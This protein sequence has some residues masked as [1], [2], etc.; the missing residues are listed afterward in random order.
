[1]RLTRRAVFGS[2]A[3]SRLLAQGVGRPGLIVRQVSPDNLES[4]FDALD[5]VVTPTEQFYVRS[6]F[7]VPALTAA[8]FRLRVEGRVAQPVQL[9]YDELL[10]MPSRTVTAT[11]ECAGNGRVFLSPAAAGVQW[12]LGAVSTAEW[13]GVPLAAVL[14]RAG[15]QPAA[16][17]IV[18]E[19]ADRGELRNDPRPPGPV[20]FARS[21]PLA[22]ARQP[23]VLLA[24]HMNGQ[25]LTA[26]HGFPLRAV[27][28]GWYGMASVKW[29]HRIVALDRPFTGYYQTV[30]YAYWDR[31]GP[32]P[33][34]RPMTEMT[35]KASIAR[36]LAREV[37]RAGQ[38]YRVAGTAWTGGEATVTRVEVS[39]D[40]GR[41]WTTAK[42]LDKPQPYVWTRWEHPWTPGQAGSAVLMARATDSRGRTQPERHNA[43]LG[44]YGIS[45]VL[46]VGVEVR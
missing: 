17:D 34:R 29:L 38:A 42:L 9:S 24:T 26:A 8:D 28:P 33:E 14:E 46:P 3:V 5:A 7:A 39:V 44:S 1:M 16:V 31:S 11:L 18:L 13:R 15:L 40:G 21:L 2:L 37:V 27:M 23:E 30:D 20:H 36:P 6:H 43:D 32:S 10:G 4:P 35:V 25:P 22:Q 45:H 41:T 19:G 12:G